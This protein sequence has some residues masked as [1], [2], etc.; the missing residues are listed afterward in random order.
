MDPLDPELDDS[1]NLGL[2]ITI[3]IVIL[4]FIVILFII[5]KNAGLFFE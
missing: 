1:K 2:A 5:T 3:A 4:I